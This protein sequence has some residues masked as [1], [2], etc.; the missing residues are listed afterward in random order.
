MGEYLRLRDNAELVDLARGSII[1]NPGQ[2]F[3]HVHFPIEGYVSLMTGITGGLY[4]GLMLT[5]REGML[6]SALALGV[7]ASPYR[8]QVDGAGMALRME[9]TEFRRELA[10]SKAMRRTVGHYIYAQSSQLAQAAYCARF[11]MI[12]NRLSHWLLMAHDRAQSEYLTITQTS[13]AIALG[14]RRCSI[15][16]AACSLQ[17]KHLIDYKRGNI[18]ILDHRG[19]ERVCCDCYQI[20]ERLYGGEHLYGGMLDR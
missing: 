19:L 13:L 9:A 11:H 3:D 2:P 5:G 10:R 6:G 14:V 16:A 8:V 7:A 1:G 17:R 20:T 15:T 12:E 4:F 18:K